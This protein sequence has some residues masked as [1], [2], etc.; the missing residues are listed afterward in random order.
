MSED[1]HDP[2]TPAEEPKNPWAFLESPPKEAPEH[3]PDVLRIK[4]VSAAWLAGYILKKGCLTLLIIFGTLVGCSIFLDS[5]YHRDA[6]RIRARAHDCRFQL[7]QI[8]IGLDYLTH[9]DRIPEKLRDE[10]EPV[11]I[12]P[13][14]TVANLIREALRQDILDGGPGGKYL[15][16]TRTGEPYLVFPAPASVLLQ[17]PEPHKHIPVVMDPPHAHDESKSLTFVCRLFYGHSSK[18]IST[19][20]V[21]YADGGIE[22]I[23]NEEAEKLVAEHAPVPIEFDSGPETKEKSDE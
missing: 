10:I 2:N 20:R 1:L 3:E 18:Y 23:S 16:C 7:R 11:E 22:T 12:T 15:C 9:P 13:D 4:D 17:E 6:D 14:M 8:S 19:V 5:T 21:L